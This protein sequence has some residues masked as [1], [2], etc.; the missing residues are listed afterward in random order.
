MAYGWYTEM[1]LCVKY[2]DLE[3]RLEHFNFFSHPVW[4]GG[5]WSGECEWG[6]VDYPT[7]HR[8]TTHLKW[9]A[10]DSHNAVTHMYGS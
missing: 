3:S 7:S 10:D 2:E 5:G 6:V 8:K 9:R 4:A 1:L